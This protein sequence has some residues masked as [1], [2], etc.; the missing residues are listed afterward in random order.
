MTLSAARKEMALT[1]KD[2]RPTLARKKGT[3]EYQVF[4][5]FSHEYIKKQGF[6][7]CK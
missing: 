4:V 3:R 2:Q 5:Y 1:D 7:V 6:V